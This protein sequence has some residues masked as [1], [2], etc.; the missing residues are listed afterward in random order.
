[1]VA[2]RIVRVVAL[3]LVALA[4]GPLA[5]PASAQPAELPFKI[6]TV[7]GSGD[8]YRAG[9]S[10]WAAARL[11]AEVGAGDGART[12]AGGRLTLKT[13]S[14]QSLRL[15]SLSRISVLAPAA[16]AEEPTRVRMDGGAVWVAVRP[17]SPPGESIEVRTSAVVVTVR[18]GGV[19]IALRPDGSVQVRVHHGNAQCSGAGPGPQ[20]ARPLVTGQELL[21]AAVGPP[22]EMRKLSTD[23]A[24]AEWVKWNE[25]QDL[26]GGY[27]GTPS[28][29]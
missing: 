27:G 25:D 28:E 22:G 17:G 19:G 6:V 9:A 3:A 10:T 4:G 24:E 14:G 8:V 12:L 13:A 16:S 1:M 26:A 11:R 7:A 2:V 29:R 21:V 23:K 20:W 18:D 5:V 15:A